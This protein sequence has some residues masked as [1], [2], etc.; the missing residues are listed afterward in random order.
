MPFTNGVVSVAASAVK[1]CTVG[2]QGVLVQN[3]G[4]VVVTLGGPGVVAGQGPTLAVSPAAPVFVPGGQPAASGLVPAGA[5]VTQD[6]YGIGAS[7][8]PTSVVFITP[9]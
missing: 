2:P 1:I 6:L 9:D 8:G 3:L 7:A 4:A 5:T